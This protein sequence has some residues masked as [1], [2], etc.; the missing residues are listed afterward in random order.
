MPKI[1]ASKTST[2]QTKKATT[3]AA[4]TPKASTS[5][6]TSPSSTPRSPSPADVFEAA[7]IKAEAALP[8]GLGK[9][10]PEGQ[11]GR[12]LWVWDEKAGSL[13]DAGRL[14]VACRAMGITQLYVNAYPPTGAHAEQLERIVTLAA[15]QGIE[16]QLLV[17]DPGWTD[18]G[19][20]PWIASQVLEP[21]RAMLDRV[22]AKNPDLTVKSALHLDVEP[23]ATGLTAEKAQAY[24]D[25]LGWFRGQWSGTLAADVPGWFADPQWQAS[26]KPLGEAILDHADQLTLMAYSSAPG[27]IAGIA[28]PL[29]KLASAQGKKVVVGVE[30]RPSAENVHLPSM[31]QAR[32]AL[33][34]VDQRFATDAAAGGYSGLAVH[35]YASLLTLAP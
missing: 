9:L 35:D 10:F 29:V 13:P 19:V 6:T 23:Q 27:A 3:K 8:P 28:E 11:K 25:M 7:A 17:G 1:T 30:T 5:T 12:A 18:P 24:V 31:E 2:G 20:R 16:T 21:L 22:Q 33:S 14:M 26:G 34:Q 4:E 32:D 15:Q